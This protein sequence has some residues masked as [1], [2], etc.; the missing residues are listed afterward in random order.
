MTPGN[1]Q[2]IQ[3]LMCRAMAT[4]E[5]RGAIL[6]LIPRDTGPG[7]AQHETH[8]AVRSED[9]HKVPHLLQVASAE[10]ARVLD[11]HQNRG[12]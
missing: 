8:L 3:A 11:H 7:M 6:T 12:N 4:I 10:V 5:A 9:L 2:A 1:D